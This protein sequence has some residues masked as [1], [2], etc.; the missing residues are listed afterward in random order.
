MVCF[1]ISYAICIIQSNEVNALARNGILHVAIICYDFVLLH[2]MTTR[3][4]HL[5]YIPKYQTEWQIVFAVAHRIHD[6]IFA[7]IQLR[8]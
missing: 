4:L 1:L 6:V 3:T 5:R 7:S 8:S 2:R